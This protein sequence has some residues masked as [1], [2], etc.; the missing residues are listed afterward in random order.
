MLKVICYLLEFT[1]KAKQLPFN[2]YK[3]FFEKVYVI[4]NYSQC[5]LDNKYFIF[6]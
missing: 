3:F 4:L 2:D 6:E 5:L 1:D